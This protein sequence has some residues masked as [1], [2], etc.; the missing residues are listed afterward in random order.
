MMYEKGMEAENHVYKKS[1]GCAQVGKDI[2]EIK[3]AI[4]Q[5]DSKDRGEK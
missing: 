2:E 1:Q 5:K 4:Y 3:K